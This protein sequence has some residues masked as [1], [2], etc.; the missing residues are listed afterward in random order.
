MKSYC[1]CSANTM[2]VQL[3]V[4]NQFILRLDSSVEAP[5]EQCTA[6]A[7][8]LLGENCGLDKSDPY[9]CDWEGTEDDG[10]YTGVLDE[11]PPWE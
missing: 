10:V 4:S 9:E 5:I 1:G 6:H 3:F 11:L 2:Y 8:V 7:E